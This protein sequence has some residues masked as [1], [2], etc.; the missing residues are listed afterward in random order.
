MHNEILF[1]KLEY[2]SIENQTT[3]FPMHFH[4]TFCI[5]LIYKGI[6]QIQFE[7]QNLFTEVG[8]ISITNP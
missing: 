1:D 3:S 4:E 8:S 2:I 6:E 5:S 7:D